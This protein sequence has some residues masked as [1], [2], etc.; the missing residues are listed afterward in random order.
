MKLYFGDIKLP[1]IKCTKPTMKLHRGRTWDYGWNV[2][3]NKEMIKMWYDSSWG[4]MLYFEYQQQWYKMP[5][6]TEKYGKLP[7]YDLDPTSNKQF[8]LTTK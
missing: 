4:R 2:F 8:Q 3:I 7:E 5:M 6:A 1:V